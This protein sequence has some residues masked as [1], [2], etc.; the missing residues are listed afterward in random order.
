[1]SN[2]HIEDSYRISKHS[3][4]AVLAT[5]TDEQSQEVKAHRCQ[6]SLICEW[7]CHNALYA[8]GLWRDRTRSVDLNYPNK[9]AW[10]YCIVG[11]L[12]YPFI[13]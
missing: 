7:S 3:F 5:Y 13:R 10:L 1:M 11:T 2:I 6:Y 4:K 9:W 12:A 8:L